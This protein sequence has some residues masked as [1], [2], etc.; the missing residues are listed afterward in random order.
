VK[1]I[2][3]FCLPKNKKVLT[4]WHAIMFSDYTQVKYS[5]R[6]GKLFGYTNDDII[7]F[8]LANIQ[9]DCMECLGYHRWSNND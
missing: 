5:I 9:C 3:V 6:M 1:D 2:L 7:E 4:E 8:L